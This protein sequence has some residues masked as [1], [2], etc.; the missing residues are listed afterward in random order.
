MMGQSRYWG[1]KP[2]YSVERMAADQIQLQIRPLS[3][4]RHS[5]TSALDR[6]SCRNHT[7]KEKKHFLKSQ[8]VLIRTEGTE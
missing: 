5:L 3:A 6:S 1:L 2:N 7:Q 4:L 8:L